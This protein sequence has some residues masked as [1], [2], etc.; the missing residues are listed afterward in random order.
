MKHSYNC[1]RSFFLLVGQRIKSGADMVAQMFQAEAKKPQWTT[2]ANAS[3]EFT[4]F[5]DS[6]TPWVKDAVFV[7]LMHCS[8][9]HGTRDQRFN[10][11]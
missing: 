8:G 3:V 10:E 4:E 5:F 11:C 1:V 7:N 9:C 2:H 6:L